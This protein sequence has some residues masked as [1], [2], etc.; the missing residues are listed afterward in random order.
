M[1]VSCCCSVCGD[2]L[3]DVPGLT[4]SGDFSLEIEPCQSCLDG[5]KREG[6]DGAES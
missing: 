2:F 6:H 4:R 1:D 3:V 5:A